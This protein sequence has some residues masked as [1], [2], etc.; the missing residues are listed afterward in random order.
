MVRTG[1]ATHWARKSLWYFKKTARTITTASSCFPSSSSSPTSDLAYVHNRGYKTWKPEKPS[2]HDLGLQLTPGSRAFA[3]CEYAAIRDLFHA[4]SQTNPSADGGVDD[5]GPYL[6]ISGVRDLL[7]SIGERPDDVTLREIFSAVDLSGDGRIHLEEFLEAAD[8]ILGDSPARI[9]LVV[10]GP[11]SGKG[12]ICRRLEEECGAVHMSSGELLRSE[13]LR[14]TP[15]GKECA[16]IMER[17]ELVS[18]AVITALI[19]RK[20]RDYPGRRV[21]LDG[22]PRSLESAHDFMELCGKP[23][24]ALHLDCDDTVLMERI[25]NRS[26][27][28]TTGIPRADDNIDSALRRLRTFHKYHRPTM[29][30][31][32]EQHVPIVNIDCS[33]TPE[34]VWEQLLAIGRLMRPAASFGIDDASVPTSMFHDIESYETTIA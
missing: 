16:S 22:F 14:S 11:G 9:V 3:D 18:S 15:L 24:L 13:V 10:G 25:I 12:M 20:M 30:W 17:G 1:P 4:F 7:A 23:E 34:N 33:G 6:G 5:L 8:R 26:K 19:R 27:E 32:K 29:E 31:L 2:H 21:L 28:H